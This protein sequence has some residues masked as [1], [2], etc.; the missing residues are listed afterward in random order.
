MI[1]NKYKFVWVFN[2]KKSHFPSGVFEEKARAE[3]WINKH[4]LTGTLT[5]YPVNISAYD[6]AVETAMFEPKKDKEQSSEFI[7]RFTSGSQEHY[8]Y[9]D[10]WD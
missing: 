2:G 6:W 1:E 8:H 3:A 4:K 7:G 9:G 5:Q 10:D